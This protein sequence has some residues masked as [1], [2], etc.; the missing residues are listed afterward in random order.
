MSDCKNQF[1]QN[2]ISQTLSFLSINQQ[3]QLQSI[4]NSCLYNYELS[5]KENYNELPATID[6]YN[7]D[8]LKRFIVA[9]TIE[10]RSKGTIEMYAYRLKQFIISLSKK[11]NQVSPDDVRYYLAMQK[12]TRHVSNTTLDHIRACIRSLFSWMVDEEYIVKNP[13]CKIGTISHSTVKEDPFTQSELEIM[14]TNC[15]NERDRALIEFLVSTGCRV[16]ECVSVNVNDLDFVAKELNVL[17][18][19]NK[20]RTVYL[21]DRCIVYLKMYL[22]QRKDSNEALFVSY[23]SKARRISVSAVQ[24]SLHE[25]GKSCNISNVHPHRFRRTMCCSLINKGVPLQDVQQIMGHASPDTT[26]IYYNSSSTSIKHKFEQ[27]N[28]I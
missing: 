5:L 19:G 26:L 27:V 28:N 20:W 16:S 11:L 12:S 22:N 8:I 17:G 21:S 10:G 18:K 14:C 7:G 9:K 13:A 25:L 15:K 6:D 3:T 2:V 1:I 24:Q 4:L 23:S